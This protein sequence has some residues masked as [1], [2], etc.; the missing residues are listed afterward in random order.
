MPSERSENDPLP[1]LGDAQFAVAVFAVT[2]F[3]LIIFVLLVT[4]CVS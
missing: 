2:S 4:L 1:P 3:A